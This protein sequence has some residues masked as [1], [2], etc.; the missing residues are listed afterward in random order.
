MSLTETHCIMYIRMIGVKAVEQS[1][2][3]SKVVLSRDTI[4]SHTSWV[5][6]VWEVYPLSFSLG[7]D[8]TTIMET[9]IPSMRRKT[10]GN[11]GR[12]ENRWFARKANR[13]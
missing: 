13:H 3:S 12:L 10:K 2:T 4:L 7:M 5:H 1:T 6:V 9:I 11:N 8:G